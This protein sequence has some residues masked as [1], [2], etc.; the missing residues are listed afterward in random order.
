MRRALVVIGLVA[1]L[2]AC[3]K[4]AKP[5]QSIAFL[6]NVAVA[7]E[8]QNALLGVLA[9]AGWKVGDN[10][11]VLDPDVSEVHE[12]PD[13]AEAAIKSWKK[14]GVDLIVALSTPAAM[15]ARDAAGDTP[16]LALANDPVASG[17]VQNPDSPEGHVTGVAFRTPPDRTI[18]VATRITSAIKTVGILA[19]ANDPA[20]EP[21][22]T[23]LLAAARSLSVRTVDETFAGP[24]D[25]ASAIDALAAGGA[26]VVVLVNSSAT[27]RAYQPISVA[28]LRNKLPAV[29]NIASNPFAS[30]VL[31]PD[32][33]AAYR[34]LGR[35]AARLLGGAK[36]AEVPLEEPGKFRLLVRTDMAAKVGVT[37]SPD[38]ISQ[39]DDAGSP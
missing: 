1:S 9:D 14:K 30:V 24:D 12:Q 8:T 17:I 29:A 10:L 31:A 26:Q 37:I 20:G 19:P 39:A 27:V 38:L 32:G 22:R 3:G 25:A 35:Q 6:R 11:T 23:G 5:D 18:D 28:L 7:E 13:D 15:V 33:D 16:V 4:D 21:V 2:V 34:Q 36:V